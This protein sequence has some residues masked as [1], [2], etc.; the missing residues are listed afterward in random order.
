MPELCLLE[1]EKGIDWWAVG[2]NQTPAVLY[3]IVLT[4]IELLSCQIELGSRGPLID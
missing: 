1:A 4:C 2:Q 3:C